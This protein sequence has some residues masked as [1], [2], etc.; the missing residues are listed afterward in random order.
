[1]EETLNGYK[2]YFIFS[3][4]VVY[5]YELTQIKLKL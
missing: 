1:M 2:E 5:V 4:F 3:Y